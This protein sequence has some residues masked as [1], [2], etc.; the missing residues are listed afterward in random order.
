MVDDNG[1]ARLA[2]AGRSSIVAA[3]GTSTSRHVQSE[4]IGNAGNFRY[5]APEVGWP[6]EYGS[7]KVLITKE[8]DMYGM[9][10]VIYEV[11]LRL[12]VPSGR[13]AES[14]VDSL[15]LDREEAVLQS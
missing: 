10:M 11:S 8:S 9:A 3:R 15:G 5:S 13:R 4:F 2:T 1:N 12:A 7:Y 6:E 14:D